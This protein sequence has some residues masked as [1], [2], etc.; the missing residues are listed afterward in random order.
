MK[1]RQKARDAHRFIV[2]GLARTGIAV[3]R[4]LARQGQKVTVVERQT[5]QA[6]AKTLEQ[7]AGLPIEF[8]WEVQ[9]LESLPDDVQTII[10]SPGVPYDL[11][12][13]EKARQ[14][15]IETISGLAWALRELPPIPTIAVTGSAG[16]STTV[17]LIG[18][19]FTHSGKHCFVGGNLGT[20]LASLLEETSLP[21]ILV[22]ECSSFQLEATPALPAQVA[23]LT[24]LRPNHLD[25]HKTMQRYAACKARLFEH[26]PP[27]SWTISRHDDPDSELVVANTPARRLFFYPHGTSEQGAMLDE[28]S[29]ILKHPSFGTE[30]YSLKEFRL[31]GH[32]NLENLMAAAL[33][34]R[35]MG[36]TPEAIQKT[37]RTFRGLEHR[38]E[39]ITEIDGVTYF[40][41]S[42]ATTPDSALNAIQAFGKTK[43]LHILLG[44][45]SKGT[46][47][48][49]LTQA[50]Q[51]HVKKA[52]LFGEAA[53]EIR[54]DIEHSCEWNSYPSL[55]EALLA[56]S[57][58]A[59]QGDV[60][61]L[62]PAC[63]SFDEFANFEERGRQFKAWV[64][65]L[66]ST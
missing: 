41:D 39:W 17:T 19:M 51:Q 35:L 23:I 20:P 5:A 8:L 22:L 50:L 12:S 46:S 33:A 48:K 62:S 54:A 36:A 31:Q 15:G 65:Q 6:H 38:L 44:G 21:D 58:T 7:L 29:L 63:T 40:N 28:H 61:L 9:D 64:T 26:L 56:A 27:H 10:L 47:F 53:E 13:L 52:Y 3:A 59:S 25:R 66:T 34:A 18:E 45:R 1:N 2:W 11:P 37:I 30:S 42:K 32:H 24:N 57:Q 4:Y 14:Q 16:K 60:V 43:K 49:P 55:R